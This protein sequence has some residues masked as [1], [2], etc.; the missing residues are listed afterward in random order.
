MPIYVLKVDIERRRISLSLRP[1]GRAK[2]RDGAQR[3]SNSSD[4]DSV[5]SFAPSVV[6][7][8]ARSN[9]SIRSVV[10]SRS[11]ATEL[12]D[13]S[14]AQT[15]LAGMVDAMLEGDG[16]REASLAALKVAAKAR[17]EEAAAQE[18]NEAEERRRQLKALAAEKSAEKLEAH[19]AQP[20]SAETHDIEV[21]LMASVVKWVEETSNEPEKPR[22]LAVRKVRRGPTPAHP[23]G[24]C[25]R[26]I[27]LT[28]LPW[29]YGREAWEVRT[30]PV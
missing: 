21:P 12:S 8:S 14:R 2:E 17:R 19:K 27:T 6:S 20:L 16:S 11:R 24:G 23:S 26:T 15:Q 9:P 13:F 30:L 28:D 3:C 5:A 22:V 1:P 10:S 29:K 7:A 25:W 18:A 4:A